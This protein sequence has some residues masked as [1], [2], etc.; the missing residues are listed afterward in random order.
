MPVKQGTFGTSPIYNGEYKI[1]KI[2]NGENLVYQSFVYDPLVALIERTIEYVDTELTNYTNKIGYDAFNKTSLKS[3]NIPTSVTV[4]EGYAFANCVNLEN[5]TLSEFVTKIDSSAFYGCSS[6]STMTI[7][8]STPPTLG[9]TN[10]ISE[11]TTKIY[12]PA[13]SVN[14]YET[15]NNWKDLM[16]RTTN[17]IIFVGI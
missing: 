10:A 14:L 15:A 6:L 2:Y 7:L 12:V 16:T 13:S 17:P 11:H 3:I 8:A 9:G 1:G 4:I 5:I